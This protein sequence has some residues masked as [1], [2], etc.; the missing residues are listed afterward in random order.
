MT[1]LK[2]IAGE[3]G[4]SVPT[5]SAVLGGRAEKLGIKAETR[6]RILKAAQRM[7]YRPNLTAR[8]LR[9]RRTFTIGLMLHSPRE[10]IYAEMLSEIQSR[11]LA[12][13]YAGICAF[14]KDMAEAR[15]AFRSVLDRG[16]DGLI[17]C[18]DDLTLL[19]N[20]IPTV[21]FQQRHPRYDSLVRD[22][23]DSMRRAVNYLVDLGHRRLG[24][25]YLDRRRFG[26]LVRDTLRER[27]IDI[28]PFWTV[29]RHKDHTEAARDCLVQFFAQPPDRRP[30]AVICRNDTTA[31]TVISM[32]GANGLVVPRD[33][34]VLGSDDVTLGALTNPPL[35]TLGVPPAELAK[36]LVDLLL[37][38]L[39]RPDAPVRELLLK[40]RLIERSSCSPPRV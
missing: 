18:H 7:N 9:T 11:L 12:H 15:A 19:P 1:T 38:R 16:V 5:V 17:S 3:A 32:V 33:L 4:F 39:A 29:G 20:D 10:L 40:Q 26:E 36:R 27:G 14:W 8:G 28:E 25:I 2:D 22:G 37:R 13:G 23:D 6:T 24:T 30:T 21:L 31:M 34:S 35:T